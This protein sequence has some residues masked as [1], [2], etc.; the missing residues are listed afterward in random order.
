MNRRA[1]AHNIYI[2]TEF[3]GCS[4]DDAMR[5]ITA[6]HQFGKNQGLTRLVTDIVDPDVFGP[7]ADVRRRGLAE[8]AQTNLS[9]HD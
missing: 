6:P 5:S 4:E 7:L 9:P 8:I 2:K 1:Q 3:T